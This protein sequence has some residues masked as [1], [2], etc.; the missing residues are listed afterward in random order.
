MKS[1]ELIKQAIELDMPDMEIVWKKC[2]EELQQE[3]KKYKE[4]NQKK[5]GRNMRKGIYAGLGVCAVDD[6]RRANLTS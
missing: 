5:A 3:T 6:R 2:I 4:T 1:S